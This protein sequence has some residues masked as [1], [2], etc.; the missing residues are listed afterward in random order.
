MSKLGKVAITTG[1]TAGWIA[2]LAAVGWP[3]LACAMLVL[4][5]VTIMLFWILSSDERTK[6]LASL[7]S[8][9]R[10]TH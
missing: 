9:I 7:I 4:V 2:G 10:G 5:L 1:T 6:R 8:A 3:T